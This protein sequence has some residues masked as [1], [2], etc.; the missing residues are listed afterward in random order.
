MSNY[1]N[2]SNRIKLACYE[3]LIEKLITSEG[4]IVS[5]LFIRNNKSGIESVMLVYYP[6]GMFRNEGG[7]ERMKPDKIVYLSPLIETSNDGFIDQ[8][9]FEVKLLDCL[10]KMFPD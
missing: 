2:K 5:P 9:P 4:Q 6:E 3:K 1:L 7:I 8:R 10:D